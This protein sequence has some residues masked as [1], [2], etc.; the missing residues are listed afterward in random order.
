ML[1]V[2]L[3]LVCFVGLIVFFIVNRRIVKKD[4]QKQLE[5]FEESFVPSEPVSIGARVM[6]KREGIIKYGSSRT[7]LHRIEYRMVFLTD[8]GKTL[9]LI[10]PEETYHKYNEYDVSTLVTVD[11]EFYHFGDGEEASADTLPEGDDYGDGAV[12]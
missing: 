12:L 6:E 9:D 8:D 4:M 3:I 1:P 10:V 5:E 2:I 11:G 7:P